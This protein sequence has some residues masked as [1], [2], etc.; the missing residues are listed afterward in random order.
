M[1]KSMR[2]SESARSTRSFALSVVGTGREAFLNETR[3]HK[4]TT[5]QIIQKINHTHPHLWWHKRPNRKYM[6]FR[7][8]IGME[9]SWL[10][11]E[12][13]PS[14]L[15]PKQHSGVR[16]P[17]HVGFNGLYLRTQG[18]DSNLNL[19]ICD[20]LSGQPVGT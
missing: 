7:Y 16:G 6:E 17:F 15:V 19:A 10:R 20:F 18:D 4:S 13:D 14:T 9:L 2:V 3:R 12:A 11:L 1:L 5:M 8:L